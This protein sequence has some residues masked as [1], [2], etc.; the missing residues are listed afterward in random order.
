M[1]IIIYCLVFVSLF[2]LFLISGC[3]ECDNNK[4]G[5]SLQEQRTLYNPYGDLSERLKLMYSPVTVIG[6]AV[7]EEYGVFS[8]KISGYTF[9]VIDA[10]NNIYLVKNVMI[11][12]KKGDI[13]K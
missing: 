9:Y 6:D 4:Q 1:K 13:L 3:L 7:P 8:K 12:P 5:Y 2:T 11:N 10:S